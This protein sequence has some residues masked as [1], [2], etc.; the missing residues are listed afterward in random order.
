MQNS[1]K[2]PPEP[3]WATTESLVFQISL[4]IKRN[5]L[6]QGHTSPATKEWG[7]IL[8]CRDFAIARRWQELAHSSLC[9]S[10]ER[11]CLE[12]KHAGGCFEGRQGYGALSLAERDKK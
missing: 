12:V 2:E 3:I 1:W 7:D 11:Q 4:W 5:T 10:P 9:S 6:V 8:W